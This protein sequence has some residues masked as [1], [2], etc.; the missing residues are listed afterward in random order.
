M[1]LHFS[2]SS[3][4]LL[5]YLLCFHPREGNRNI[6]QEAQGCSVGPSAATPESHQQHVLGLAVPQAVYN[7]EL[8]GE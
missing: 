6:A 4:W 5:G 2:Y 8:Q 3:A 1:L 7:Y